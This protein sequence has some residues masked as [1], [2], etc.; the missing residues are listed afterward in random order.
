MRK[1]FLTLSSFLLLTQLYAQKFEVSVLANSGLFHY[2]GNGTTSA[3]FINYTQ[4]SSNSY[5]NYSFGNKN[6]F[7]YGAAVQAQFVAK[8]GFISGLQAGYDVLR[9]TAD[10]TAVDG[11]VILPFYNTFS[12]NTTPVKGSSVVQNEFI[13]LNP[14]VGYRL[15]IKTINI[16]LLIGLDLPF[17]VGSYEKSSSTAADGTVY[18]TYVNYGKGAFDLRDRFG[19]A[20][21]YHRYGLTAS[22]AHGLINHSADLMDDSP[23]VY[24][25]HS[26]LLRFGISYRIL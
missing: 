23:T 20:A 7:S 11:A 10:I 15:P 9:S 6:G 22:Y 24:E 13:N 26:E 19:I 21:S 25:A 8:C 5:P 2:S 12:S 18:K 16:D 1:T 4:G 17:G 3:S 14:F